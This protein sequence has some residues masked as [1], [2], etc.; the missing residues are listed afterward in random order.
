MPCGPADG[1][2]EALQDLVACVHKRVNAEG[3]SCSSISFVGRTP[4]FAADHW[5]LAENSISPARAPGAGQGTRPGPA[6]LILG[7]T[8]NTK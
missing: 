2:S 5:D 8:V 7:G 3:T 1:S 4:P 6:P